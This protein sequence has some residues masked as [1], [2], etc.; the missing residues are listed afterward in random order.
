MTL[1]KGGLT[2]L[3]LLALTGFAG[4]SASIT[5]ACTRAVYLGKEGMVV[6]G[7]TMDWAED[8]HSNI[9]LFPRGMKRDGGFDEASVKWTSKYGSIVTSVYESA[10]ADGMNEKGLVA[11][12]LYLA[13]SDYE[14]PGDQ[15]PSLM[16]SAW[17][18][19]FLDNFATVKEAVEDAKKEAYRIVTT[20]AP[21]GAKGT[22]H[23]SISDPTGDSAIFEYVKGKLVI[24]H[25]R[26]FQVMTNSPVFDEQIAL[27]KYWEQ[28]GGTVMLPGTNR[29]ADR[30]ARASFYVNACKQSADPHEAVAC[31]LSVMR[32]VSVPIGISTPN[33]PNISSTLWRTASN[34]KNLVYFFESTLSPSLVWIRLKEL[35]FSEAA[36]V[37]KLVLA[38]R[39]E[40][41]GD[42]TRGFEKAAPFK[43]LAPEK[44]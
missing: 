30:F 29:A 19:Y 42:Q 13:E 4:F 8:M 33:Q 7:R 3:G 6:T 28:I 36:G 1:T 35:D 24:H 5:Q 27:N 10:S 20:E 14:L 16:I 22:V 17:A 39:P 25:S 44:K 23:L 15:R 43:F 26:D 32:N 18:Q 40:L 37:R 41:G 12:L 34:Q 31:A 21:N 2:T 11:N 38:G 9:W